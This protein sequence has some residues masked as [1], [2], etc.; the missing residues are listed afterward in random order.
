MASWKLA[1]VTEL[2]KRHG[3]DVD[4]PITTERPTMTTHDNEA[5]FF[6]QA[7]AQLDH[8]VF[9]VFYTMKTADVYVTE[10]RHV[11]TEP[12]YG[13]VRM[14]L[15]EVLEERDLARGR[16]TLLTIRSHKGFPVAL[17]PDQI[18][19]I[20]VEVIGPDGEPVLPLKPGYADDVEDG[21][22]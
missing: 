18:A 5:E 8:W 19:S 17:A 15:E 12:H 1:A 9:R 4:A 2:L 3:V 21:Q 11:H 7:H 22:Q 13:D 16:N 14:V 20:R 10:D 6:D